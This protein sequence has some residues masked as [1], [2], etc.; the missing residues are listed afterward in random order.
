MLISVGNPYPIISSV[1]SMKVLL[2][3]KPERWFM[4]EKHAPLD[5]TSVRF[6]II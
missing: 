4:Q 2:K 1:N 6:E 5:I 3:K